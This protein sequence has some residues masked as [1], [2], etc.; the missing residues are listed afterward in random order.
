MKQ[1]TILTYLFGAFLYG[2]TPS[3]DPEISTGQLYEYAEFVNVGTHNLTLE[4]VQGDTSLSYTSLDSENQSLGFTTDNYWLRFQLENSS[5]HP[6]VYYLE[7]A[8]PITDVSEL[9]Q[10]DDN[11]MKSFKSGDQIPFDERQVKHR[12]TIF[13]LELPKQSTQQFY[14]HFKSDGETINLPLIL[15]NEAD[16]WQINY[17]QQ[18]FLGLFYGLLFLAGIIYLFFYTSL[19]VISLLQSLCI[20]YCIH[21]GRIGRIDFSICTSKW[22]VS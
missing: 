5:N 14:L 18:L 2:Q 8:R 16:F 11:G 3:F 22:R 21:A 9:Y 12:A 1:L 19:K 15:S 4:E 10:L 13:K 20:L 7:T 17:K 6:T